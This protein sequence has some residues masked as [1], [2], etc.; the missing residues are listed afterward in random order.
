MPE[1]DENTDMQFWRAIYEILQDA[2]ET[3]PYFTH[4]ERIHWTHPDD[5]WKNDAEV[6]AIAED[7]S[8]EIETLIQHYCTKRCW[9]RRSKNNAR[10]FAS[11]RIEWAIGFARIFTIPPAGS[12]AVA[13]PRPPQNGWELLQWLLKDAYPQR[14][15]PR[16]KAPFYIS[17]DDDKMIEVWT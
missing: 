14:F 3:L 6:E 16:Q 11:Q 8:A 2:R 17:G 7:C 9:P 1:V 15:P 13:I 10:Y 5:D 4:P 12:Q